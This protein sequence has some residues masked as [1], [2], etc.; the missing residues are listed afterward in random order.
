[1]HQDAL[2]ESAPVL[3]RRSHWDTGGGKTIASLFVT[4]PIW[5]AV[6]QS[7]TILARSSELGPRCFQPGTQLAT[8]RLERSLEL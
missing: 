7:K 2:L 8:G 1:M 3:Q 4:Q 6:R 5:F